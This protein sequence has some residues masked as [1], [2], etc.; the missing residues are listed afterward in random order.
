MQPDSLIPD[1]S[2]PQAFNRF[3]YVG[4]NPVNF[5][6]PTGHYVCNNIYGCDGPSDDSDV[7]VVS[8]GGNG[9]NDDDD[10][11]G[12]GGGSCATLACLIGS[13]G[14]VFTGGGSGVFNNNLQL[15]QYIQDY[16]YY[17]NDY[18]NDTQEYWNQCILTCHDATMAT[19]LDWTLYGQEEPFPFLP[20]YAAIDVGVPVLPWILGVDFQLTFDKY[21]RVYFGV[22][23]SIGASPWLGLDING[24][25]SGSYIIDSDTTHE[26]AYSFITQWSGSGCGG[27]GVG[28]CVTN[29]DPFGAP[30]SQWQNWA[31]QI[32][33]FTPQ[34]GIAFPYSGQIS[35]P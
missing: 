27:Y 23:P 1:P 33:G 11:G 29:G 8:G 14:N 22:G 13:S 5:S 26:E 19:M 16:L 3:S 12:G 24:S 6:D 2:N 32:G 21:D 9:G 31:I 17:N 35:L 34:A 30:F 7:D 15:P 4:N 10:D 25:V 18:F 28:A 20:D